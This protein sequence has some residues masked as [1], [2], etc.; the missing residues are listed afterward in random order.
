MSIQVKN[1]ERVLSDYLRLDKLHLE[2]GY[3]YLLER[4]DNSVWLVVNREGS[5]RGAPMEDSFV[6]ISND[7]EY[8]NLSHCDNKFKLKGI[9]DL[10]FS[11]S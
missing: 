10:V 3:I 11:L 1:L 9:V 7:W 2:R 5:Y 8:L 4:R 6:D